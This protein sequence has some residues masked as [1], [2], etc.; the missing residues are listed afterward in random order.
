MPRTT[1][2]KNRE[3]SVSRLKGEFKELGVDMDGTGDANFTKTR[4]R[5][6]SA[7]LKS[8]K[9]LKLQDGDNHEDAGAKISRDKSGIRDPEARK[10]LKVMAKKMQKRKFAA[11]GKAG[12]SDRKITTKMPK[13]LFA[14]KRGTGKTQRR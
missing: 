11:L 4:K 7:S 1:I 6:R 8:T 10:K 3:R 12:E 9:R 13:H 5:G 2:A 14:G